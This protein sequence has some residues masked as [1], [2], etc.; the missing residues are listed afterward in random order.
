ML[1]R[2]VF[3]RNLSHF[4]L[5]YRELRLPCKNAQ[6]TASRYACRLCRATSY[7]RL[8]HRA[9]AVLWSKALSIAAQDAN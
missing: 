6:P 7:R 3:G 5:A 8:T 1:C 2:W 4:S 9:P